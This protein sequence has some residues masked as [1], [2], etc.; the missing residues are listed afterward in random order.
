MTSLFKVAL[1]GLAL[2]AP[3]SVTAE[4]SAPQ[5]HD[6]KAVR[7]PASRLESPIAQ[8]Y[9]RARNSMN[10]G[11]DSWDDE[12][13]PRV[14]R[15]AKRQQAHRHMQAPRQA[16]RNVVRSYEDGEQRAQRRRGARN[17]AA[18]VP[19][20]SAGSGIASYYWQG[21]RTASGASFNPDGLTAAHRTLPFGTRVRVTNVRNGRSVDVT[22]NDR[23]P[24]IAGRVIDLSRGAARVIG[25]TG[26]GLAQVNVQVL[27]R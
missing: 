10:D 27:G 25:M 17:A 11:W 9:A 8:R 14:S 19:S 2:A 24:F 13:R 26:Q 21:Q 16:R 22:I 7:A 4:A 6:A 15:K 1:L 12:D 20:G 3:L 18:Y 23:G 5:S